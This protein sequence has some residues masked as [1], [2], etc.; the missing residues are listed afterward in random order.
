M[1]LRRSRQLPKVRLR[2][3]LRTPIGHSKGQ[4]Q[5]ADLPAVC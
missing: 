4:L 2:G 1:T 3:I 5:V